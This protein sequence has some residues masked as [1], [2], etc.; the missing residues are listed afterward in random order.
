MTLV[1]FILDTL[2]TQSD[3]G[4]FDT[5]NYSPHPILF[6]AD[7]S[8]RLDTGERTQSVDLTEGTVLSVSSEPTAT[9][10]P[11]GTE[12]HYRTEDVVTV[13]I[14]GLHEDERGDVAN[15]AD[16]NSL[17]SEVLRALAT[18]QTYPRPSNDDH[19]LIVGDLNNLSSDRRNYYG[20]TVDVTARGYSDH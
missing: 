14:E 16:F 1:S 12:F 17:V 10:D 20:V 4:A 6:N 7:D 3:G 2:R 18:E 5:S 11:I 9:R 15:A 19:S 8:R 13:R